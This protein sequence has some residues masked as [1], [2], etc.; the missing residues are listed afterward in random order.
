MYLLSLWMCLLGVRLPQVVHALEVYWSNPRCMVGVYLPFATAVLPCAWA[1]CVQSRIDCLSGRLCM[2]LLSLWLCLLDREIV[3]GFKCAQR[4][5][6]EPKVVCARRKSGRTRGA[7]RCV[8][9]MCYGCP[10][11][12]VGLSWT[13]LDCVLAGTILVRALYRLAEPMA[14]PPSREIA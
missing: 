1:C 14:V 13:V 11:P 6:A 8:L 4:V 12:C 2:Y 3:S 5:L 10:S 9:A 7:A